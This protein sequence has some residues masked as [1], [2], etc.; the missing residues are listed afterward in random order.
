MRRTLKRILLRAGIYGWLWE[1]RGRLRGVSPRT[2]LRNRRFMAHHAPPEPVP[3]ARMIYEVVNH[4]D[5]EAFLAGGMERAGAIEHALT[6]SEF[7]PATCRRALDFGCGCGRVIRHLKDRIPAQWYGSDLNPRL[8]G[9]CRD[10]LQFATF[11]ANE[12][13][14]PLS[15]DDSFFDLVYA[16][17]VF[18]HLDEAL[19]NQWLAELRRILAPGGAL[20]VTTHGDAWLDGLDPAEARDYANGRLVVRSS[21]APGSNLCETY[22]PPDY[23]RRV[24]EPLFAEVHHLPQGDA[25]HRA[26]DIWI[27]KKLKVQS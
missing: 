18:T 1:A 17:S 25:A 11:S 16:I 2:L 13:E 20:L 22:H 3:P 4:Y 24:T 9:W 19:Q 10:N 27:L 8:A 14:P 21:Q 6:S 15:Y 7:E 23:F 5:I 12:L 26:Q